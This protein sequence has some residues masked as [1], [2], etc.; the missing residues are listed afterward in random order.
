MIYSGYAVYE[1]NYD[2]IPVRIS[3]PYDSQE[4][5]IEFHRVVVRK[6]K[7]RLNFKYTS[8]ICYTS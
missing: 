2:D 3:I 6:R 7:H 5:C 4:K 1:E 8:S